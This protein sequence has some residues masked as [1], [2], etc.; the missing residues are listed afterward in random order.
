[1][2]VST[3]DRKMSSSCIKTNAISG[4]PLCI[5]HDEFRKLFEKSTNKWMRNQKNNI[6]FIFSSLSFFQS[7]YSKVS[8]VAF[9][10]FLKSCSKELGFF[11]KTRNA[12]QK[13]DYQRNNLMCNR[14][15]RNNLTCNR[16]WRNNLTCNRKWRSKLT[17]NR[18]W[19]SNLTCNRKWRSN[20]TFNRKWRNNLMCNRK[21]RNNLTCN[22]KWRNNL[23]FNRKWRK[24]I[25]INTIYPVCLVD[26][27]FENKLEKIDCKNNWALF[28]FSSW[29]WVWLCYHHVPYCFSWNL[30][31][32]F[33]SSIFADNEMQQITYTQNMF[34]L[35]QKQG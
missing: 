22:R 20:L 29:L 5:P 25:A 18:K 12:F 14:M 32:M 26:A 34:A 7:M 9:L 19:R 10:P 4:S 11:I 6:I 28:N 24:L 33:L 13:K 31:E 21:W 3:V 8:T 2:P 23:T 16:K 17:C 35:Q 27:P 1:M 15:W 30:H